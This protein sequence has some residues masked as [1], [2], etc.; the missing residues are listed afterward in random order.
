[1]KFLLFSEKGHKIDTNK[2][3]DGIKIV[4]PQL[5]ISPPHNK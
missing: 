5:T 2:Y 1:M 3:Y 4:E